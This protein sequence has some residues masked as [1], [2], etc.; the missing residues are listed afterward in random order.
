MKYIVHYKS[1]KAVCPK[2]GGML[3]TL[4]SDTIVLHCI[5][6]DTYLVLSGF[7][8]ADSELEFTETELKAR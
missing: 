8:Q 2:C 7:G 5:D 6:C 3:T 4:K 1:Q